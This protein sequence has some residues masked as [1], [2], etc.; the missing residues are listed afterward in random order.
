MVDIFYVL[1]IHWMKRVYRLCIPSDIKFESNCFCTGRTRRTPGG[2]SKNC[3]NCLQSIL[4]RRSHWWLRN[5]CRL[6]YCPMVGGKIILA[7]WF[8][9]SIL[10]HQTCLSNCVGRDDSTSNYS[11]IRACFF[12]CERDGYYATKWRRSP[13]MIYR[14]IISIEYS[15]GN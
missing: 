2:G 9:Y 14:G 7:S 4:H 6:W 15:R 3:W 5:T 12:F 11:F 8:G 1:V 13:L 10:I